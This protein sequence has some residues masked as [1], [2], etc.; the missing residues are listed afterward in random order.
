MESKLL[1]ECFLALKKKK[2]LY[3]QKKTN[4]LKPKNYAILGMADLS[5]DEYLWWP[6]H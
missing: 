6:L 4:L 1:S 3:N 5:R 2:I